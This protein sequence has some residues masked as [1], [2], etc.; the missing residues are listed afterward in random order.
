M[1]NG[2]R[3]DRPVSIPEPKRTDRMDRLILIM[4][5]ALFWAVV[6]GTWASKNTALP[7]TRQ[8]RGWPLR[9]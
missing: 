8:C 1:S 2:L 5:L 4:A 6:T 7:A 9:E 3:K